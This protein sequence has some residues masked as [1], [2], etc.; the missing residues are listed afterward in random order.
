MA[1]LQ[2]LSAVMTGLYDQP[3]LGPKPDQLLIF[4]RPQ[5][6]V[7]LQE[8]LQPATSAAA[9]HSNLNVVNQA[10]AAMY[11]H[12]ALHDHVA[13]W[14]PVRSGQH[15]TEV[16]LS[17]RDASAQHRQQLA[18]AGTIQL[19]MHGAATP[20]SLPVSTVASKQ[21]PDVTMVR[22]HNVPG[23]INVHGL[24]ACLLKHFQFG[25]EYT[26]VSEYGGDAS[27]D[28]AAAIPTWCRSDVCIAELRAPVSDAKLSRLPSAFTCFGQQVS[29]SVQPSILAKA[30]LYQLRAQSQMQQ[31]AGSAP[32]SSLPPRT[33][34]RQRQRARAHKAA[35]RQTQQ[36]QQQQQQGQQQ[37][38]QQHQAAHAA[39]RPAATDDSV[40]S[41]NRLVLGRP[42]DPVLD[43]GGQRGRAGLGHSTPSPM[44]LD[45]QQASDQVSSDSLPT[46]A[47]TPGACPTPMQTTAGP[48]PSAAVASAADAAPAPE[49]QLV[50]APML[51][52][53]PLPLPPDFPDTTV[54][55][56]MCLWAEE[57]DISVDI[58]R[59]AVVHV[60]AN[61]ATE[62]SQH[63]SVDHIC[64]PKP[65]QALMVR[66]IGA[67]TGDAPLH[68]LGS[69][70]AQ[71]DSS[72]AA[73]ASTAADSPTQP[74]TTAT[75]TE[76]APRRSGRQHTP[77][78]EYW[79]VPP[80][81][82]GGAQ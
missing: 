21:L 7:K 56:A 62:L 41:A 36:Q 43:L 42:L 24:M 37:Q 39:F 20:V 72:E 48:S 82:P 50:D 22:M 73:A 2:D 8:L 74:G 65:L 75:A 47:A 61:F 71:S 49:P 14:A 67:I 69:S 32:A 40:P 53:L 66:A 4:K 33:K 19:L 9:K 3:L 63:P 60:H 5:L 29:V 23:G 15:N 68:L 59:Q 26:V 57:V 25:P 16:H 55:S 27:G 46:S 13:G 31:P 28:I 58:A 30:H 10:I 12:P 78:T 80:A 70:D 81:A 38:R 45:P 77:A 52:A 76:T 18:S 54:S 79:K 44:S 34:R 11:E 1:K 35:S 64:L 51:P 6:A 17:F